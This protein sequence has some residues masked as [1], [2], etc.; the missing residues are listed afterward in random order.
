LE[1]FSVCLEGPDCCC[2]RPL[3]YPEAAISTLWAALLL[4]ARLLLAVNYLFTVY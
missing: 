1:D 2:Y 4:L 3:I